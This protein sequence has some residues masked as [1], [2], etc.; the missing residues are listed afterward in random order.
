MWQLE[1]KGL[2]LSHRIWQMLAPDFSLAVE[3][4]CTRYWPMPPSPNGHYPF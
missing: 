2:S 3:A 4:R 1:E